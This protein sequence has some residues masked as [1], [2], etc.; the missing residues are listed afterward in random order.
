MND[1]RSSRSRDRRFSLATARAAAREGRAAEWVGDF[2][3]SR[4]SDNAA[5]A[6]GLARERH[7]WMGPL[8]V[9]VADLVPL[10]GPADEDV[11]C[12]IEPEEWEADVESM[13]A[14][15]ED[16]WDPPPLLVEYR[17]G[18]LMLQDGNHRY[19]ALVRTGAPRAWVLVYGPDTLDLDRLVTSATSEGGRRAR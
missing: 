12:P 5:L 19:E 17:N 9:A 3:A 10:A 2:L 7:A 15:I 11:L 1:E 16:G 13:E 14:S 8:E 18:A 6:A 4:G